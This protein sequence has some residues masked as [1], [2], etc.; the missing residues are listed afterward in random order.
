MKTREGRLPGAK[1]GRGKTPEGGV[2]KG[3]DPAEGEMALG[4]GKA[5]EVGEM[6][7]AIGEEDMTAATAAEDMIIATDEAKV[8]GKTV[9]EV[10]LVEEAEKLT[11][12]ADRQAEI[13][14]EI[15]WVERLLRCK[16]LSD[17]ARLSERTPHLEGVMMTRQPRKIMMLHVPVPP[18]VVMA[19]RPLLKRV[20]KALRLR[21]WLPSCSA[22]V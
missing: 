20:G 22:S 15:Q 2:L 12:G 10:G 13:G 19:S 11:D 4:E 16:S 6:I 14:L 21:V 9:R 18:I 3:G 5:V 8:M 17:R 7:P 1:I